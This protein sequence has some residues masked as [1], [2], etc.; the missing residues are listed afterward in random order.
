[1]K[2]RIEAGKAFKL[3]SYRATPALRRQACRAILSSV[4]ALA[5]EEAVSS[6]VAAAAKED[7]AEGG[8]NRCFWSK[9]QGIYAIDLQ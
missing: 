7:C 9:L 3:L 4:A 5:E 6:A 1:V 8:S 2:N